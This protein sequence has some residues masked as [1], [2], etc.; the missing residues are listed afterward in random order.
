MTKIYVLIETLDYIYGAGCCVRDG[1][2][3]HGWYLDVVWEV[4]VACKYLYKFQVTDNVTGCW[5]G[6]GHFISR[7]GLYGFWMGLVGLHG[8]GIFLETATHPLM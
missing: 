3:F 1:G 2:L 5:I 4:L 6:D 8:V 7:L